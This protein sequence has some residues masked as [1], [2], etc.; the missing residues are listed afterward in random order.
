M[1]QKYFII[2]ALVLTLGFNSCVEA[3]NQFSK[4]PP[5]IW[6]A[7]L[8]LDDKPV[9]FAKTPEE[10]E[11]KKEFDY[12]SEL[13][14]NFELV[15][16]SEDEFHI[17]LLNANEK[18]K[19]KAEDIRFGRDK[20]TAKDT[21]IFNFP[22]YD[23]YIKGIYEDGV[24]EGNWIVNYK[25]DYQ[26][27]FIAYHGKNE[28][29]FTFG[30]EASSNLTG[31]W[32]VAFEVDTEDEYPAVGEFKQEGNK[33]TGTF[34]TE[35]GDYRYLEG[36]V[37]DNKA[38]LSCFDGSHAFLFEA[39]EIEKDVLTGV[40]RSGKHYTSSWSANRVEKGNLTNPFQLTNVVGSDQLSFSFM[41]TNKE[42]VS[43]TDRPFEDKVKLVMI[44]GTWCPNCRDEMNFI[45]EYFENNPMDDVEVI[46][47]GFER[48]KDEEKSIAALKRYKDKMGLDYEVLYGGYASK[49]LASEK[50]P[51]LNK[52]ISYPTLLFVDRDNRIRKIH[53]GFNGP[54]TSKFE[55]FKTEFERTLKVLVDEQ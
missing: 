1:K 40:F 20:Q 51:M 39:K 7:V 17:V 4:L 37:F 5:G 31:D 11:Y 54:A 38:F 45:T 48:Y 6:R 36:S 12:K 10:V 16:D 52:I 50:F 26:I 55:G 33:L 13:P 32:N 19:V 41:N 21:I 43:L 8:K 25:E 34:L 18:I 42:L 24:I 23:S 3:P 47:I 44:M 9:S 46:V 29:F 49:K 30:K 27:P 14:F 2:L 28:R 35:T 15:Y 22:V 53:T